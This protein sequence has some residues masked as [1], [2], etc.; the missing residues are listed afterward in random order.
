MC[1]AAINHKIKKIMKPMLEIKISS[2]KPTKYKIIEKIQN[3][4]DVRENK[5]ISINANELYDVIGVELYLFLNCRNTTDLRN[6]LNTYFFR[7]SVKVATQ[8]FF[9][10]IVGTIGIFIPSLKRRNPNSK[11]SASALLNAEEN[12]PN[13]KNV[14]R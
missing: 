2:S 11:S 6:A 5:Y 10:T 9:V 14:S 4:I 13:L 3:K 7:P 1:L 12:P 8:P